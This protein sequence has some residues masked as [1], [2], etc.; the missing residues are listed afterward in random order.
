MPSRARSC[1]STCPV[2]I[3]LT[4]NPD[5]KAGVNY[6]PDLSDNFFTPNEFPPCDVNVTAT[7]IMGKSKPKTGLR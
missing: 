2:P 4:E 6:Y 7:E 3:P 1:R 5:F